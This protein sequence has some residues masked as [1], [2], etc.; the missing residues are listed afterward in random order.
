QSSGVAVDPDCFTQFTALRVDQRLKYIVYSLNQENTQIVIVGK[1]E[2]QNYQD[3]IAELP[4]AECRWAVYNLEY[5]KDGGKRKR[6]FFLSWKPDDAKLKDKMVLIL[7][8]RLA[9]FACRDFGRHQWS[10]R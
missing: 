4:K 7:Y 8:E 5:E 3:F 9:L 10:R 6:I 1:S 2:S